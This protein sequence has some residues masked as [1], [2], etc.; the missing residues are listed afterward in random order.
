MGLQRV[1]LD[2]ATHTQHHRLPGTEVSHD[3]DLAF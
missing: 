2:R 3:A 1:G